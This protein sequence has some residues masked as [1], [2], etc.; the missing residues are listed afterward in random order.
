MSSKPKKTERRSRGRI[1][2]V[3]IRSPIFASILVVLALVTCRGSPDRSGFPVVSQPAPGITIA[4]R[5]GLDPSVA[6]RAVRTR[7]SIERIFRALR[8][9]RHDVPAP[10]RIILYTDAADYARYAPPGPESLARYDSRHRELHLPADATP[11]DWRHEWVHVLLED[12]RPGSPYWLHEGLALFLE[13]FAGLQLPA[14]ARFDCAAPIRTALPERIQAVRP[15]LMRRSRESTQPLH[16]DLEGPYATALSGYMVFFLWHEREL[17]RFL[18][19]WLRAEPM[20]ARE[21]L[22]RQLLVD[23]AEELQQRFERWLPSPASAG[24]RPGC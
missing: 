10:V 5:P 24:S 16:A 8:A 1:F 14:S 18:R 9:G 21:T 2:A 6:P 11:A 19:R 20:P 17:G 7:D 22:Q 3:S 13:D 12:L 23:D 4:A 15:E